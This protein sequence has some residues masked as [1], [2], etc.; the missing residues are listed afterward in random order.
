VGAGGASRGGPGLRHAGAGC[1]SHRLGGVHFASG[2]AQ[3]NRRSFCGGDGA[4]GRWDRWE[5]RGCGAGRGPVGKKCGAG[6]VLSM[7]SCRWVG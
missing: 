2:A 7:A 6:L 3:W 5:R 4:A 1:G